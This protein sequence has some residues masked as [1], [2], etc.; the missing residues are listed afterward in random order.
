M[1]KVAEKVVC[2]SSMGLP[3]APPLEAKSSAQNLQKG[4]P[5]STVKNIVRKVLH[6]RS[7][8]I[9]SNLQNDGFGYAKLSFSHFRLNSKTIQNGL[10]WVPYGIPLGAVGDV[11]VDKQSVDNSF[12][13]VICYSRGGLQATVPHFP[14]EDTI[15]RTLRDDR[16]LE[17]LHFVSRGHCG[18]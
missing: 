18:G 1:E 10:Q 14:K 8:G 15:D 3:P 16:A 11:W 13:K 5:R 7:L 6:K 2:G 17:A 4:V 12:E 9:P